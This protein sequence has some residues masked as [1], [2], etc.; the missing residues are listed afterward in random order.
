MAK[1]KT[2]GTILTKDLKRLAS[3]AT[4]IEASKAFAASKEHAQKAKEALRTEI[5]KA[6]KIDGDIDFSLNAQGAL[7]TETLE[8][9]TARL[10]GTILSI[11]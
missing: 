1:T 4:Y 8:P 9:K 6:L 11:T 3:F 10:R 7:V 2:V 5:K